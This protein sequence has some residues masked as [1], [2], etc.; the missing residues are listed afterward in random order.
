MKLQ[1]ALPYLAGLAAF[2]LLPTCL[3]A[4][5]TP[6]QQ[7]VPLEVDT[8]DK[9]LAKVI[10]I[11]GT[12][13]NKPGQHE[14]FAGCALMMQW[15][16]Q[17]PG[18]WPVMVAEGWPK[19]EAIL[20]N[21]RT[22][23]CFMDGGD[24]L[25]LLEPSRWARIKKSMDE[26]AGLIMLHQAVEV[27]EAQAAEFKSWLGGVWQ[28]DIGSRGHWDMSFDAIPK[29]DTTRGVSPFA[30]PKDG[31]LF[32]IHFADKGVTPLLMGQVPDKNRTTDD[33]KSHAG[34]NEVIAWAYQR[35]NGG[36]SVGF[37]GC[38]LHSGWGVESQRRFMVNAILWTAKLPVPEGG[39]SVP[40]CGDEAL[41]A[42]W[43]RK[44]I[45]VKKAAV[46]K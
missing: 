11:A 45:G 9:S 3:L 30:A 21:A 10:L 26:G 2:S 37:T 6:Q 15:L 31:W 20:D 8:T 34:R 32:N 35:A 25:A 38:D 7:Q 24:K 13:S 42:N 5:L 28:K 40:P 29:H 17:Q 23:V 1:P 14:Y 43:D 33:A 12:P 46:V 44:A 39:A 16:K 19:N 27:P 22:I 41:A 4:D 36:R 18:V